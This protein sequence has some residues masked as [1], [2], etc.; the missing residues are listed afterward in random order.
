MR[1]TDI[2][3]PS[4]AA[5]IPPHCYV[6][7]EDTGKA[8]TIFCR[9]ELPSF[10]VLQDDGERAVPHT[11]T[12]S[13]PGLQ[14]GQI[15]QGITVPPAKPVTRAAPRSAA[16]RPS[17]APAV[18]EGPRRSYSPGTGPPAPAQPAARVSDRARPVP[19]E[20]QRGR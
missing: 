18:P 2:T 19:R 5:E 20:A 6:R 15:R 7:R 12:P 4:P 17:A 13:S 16:A 9:V 1:G 8:S 14:K 3:A 11:F 10:T